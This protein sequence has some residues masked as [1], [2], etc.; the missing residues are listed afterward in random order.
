MELLDPYPDDKPSSESY[1]S[2]SSFSS[3]GFSWNPFAKKKADPPTMSG[4]FD[5]E[6]TTESL[7]FAQ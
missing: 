3:N 2:S 5:S 6:R 4:W 1:R 7:S